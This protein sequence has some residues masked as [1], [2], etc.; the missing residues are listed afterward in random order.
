MPRWNS[1][2]MLELREIWLEYEVDSAPPGV[3]VSTL[4][5]SAFRR[6]TRERGKRSRSHVRLN[7]W[8]ILSAASVRGAVGEKM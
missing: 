4:A 7:E 5:G 3:A 8:A 2:G 1:R 6:P